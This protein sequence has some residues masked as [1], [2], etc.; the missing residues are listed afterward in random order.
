VP[1]DPGYPRE[2]LAFMVADAG[3]RVLLTQRHLVDLL[4]A[5]DAQVVCLDSDREL[6]LQE[7]R[8]NL[9]SEVQPENLF[10]VIYTSGS[11]GR[12]KGI[13]CLHGGALN[14]CKWMWETYPFDSH[15]RCGQK[16]S[17]SFADSVWEI[18]GP[19]LQGVPLVVFSEEATKDHTQFLA[20]LAVNDITRLVLVPS[21]LRSLLESGENL[22]Q[23]LPK[24]KLW[25]T[26]GEV[27]PF[28][29]AEK[30]KAVMPDCTL[31]NIY[32]SSEVSAD[33]TCH[34]LALGVESSTIP[35]G[36]PIANTRVYI[37]DRQ[38]Q[39]APVG[40]P[41]ELYIGGVVLARGYLYQPELTAERFIPDPYSSAAGA[42]LFKTGDLARYL[43]G[44]E[45]EY[46]GRIDYQVK[47]RGFRVELGEIET[48][49]KR[50][51][52]VNQSVVVEREVVPGDK[53][54][55]AYFTG[56]AEPAELRRYLKEQLPD[57]ML[58]ASFVRLESLPL[59]PNGK[60]DRRA[61]P[62]P[63]LTPVTDAEYVPPR[64]E[65]E[66][67]L[68]SIWSEV[69]RVSRVGVG[70]N[71]FELGGHSLLA[72]Q[73][74]AQINSTLQLQLPLRALFEHP[75][76]SSLAEQVEA[77]SRKGG[78][79]E[80]APIRR[81]EN[82]AKVA[83]SFAQQRLWFLDQ[84]EPDSAAYNIP[85]AVR[86]SGELNVAALERAFNEVV[87]RHESLRTAFVVEAGEPVQF[88]A[89]EVR[90]T[91]DVISLEEFEEQQREAEVARLAALEASVA[92]DLRRWPLLRIKLLRVS[93]AEHVLILV[94]HHIISDGWSM[95]VL[96]RDLCTFYNGFVS[97]QPIELK[98]LEVQYADYAVWQRGW[99]R[100]EVLEEQLRYWREQLQGATNSLELSTSHQHGDVNDIQGASLQV[101][102]DADLTAEL[103]EMSQH[104]GVTLFMLLLA[105]LGTLLYRYSGQSDIVIGTGV[106]NR[107]HREI[108][109]LIG[110]FVNVLPLRMDLTGNP[111]FRE[112]LRQVSKTALEAYA[113]QEVPFDKVVEELQP[114]RTHSHSPLFRV[115]LVLNNMV[116][117]AVELPGLSLSG[118][119]VH[120]GTSHFDL[121]VT[122]VETER[123]LRGTVEYKSALFSTEMIE[124]LLAHYEQVLRAVIKDPEQRLLEIVL[125]G[126]PT[127]LAAGDMSEFPEVFA[128]D[129]FSFDVS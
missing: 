73:V 14:R 61:L 36:C 88:I 100:G 90:L 58:P 48:V 69:L 125:T 114:E 51:A 94:M 65:T 11:T 118:M 21:L 30:F 8:T 15:E 43:P 63:D 76:I 98:D 26:S 6:I 123:G 128:N 5:H 87:R 79:R 117:P 24:L 111:T 55:V 59:T 20:T 106:A 23:R 81:A 89:D 2:R 93:A 78:G 83:L 46:L 84:L 54:L 80:S 68:T 13:S 67:L 91:L 19:L 57:Y 35:I 29:V 97:S 96:M 64:T 124:Q 22:A 56:T 32:G 45:I 110:F 62:A 7:S 12:P 49:L 122:L 42:R 108:K 75:Q 120:T 105:T 72:T 50:N 107:S 113:H 39:P 47:V 116:L 3:V 31:L 104:E 86:L 18:L 112:L 126:A 9:A 101:A 33:A 10:Y 37:L 129:Q 85:V 28:D 70:A 4:P 17:L 119:D 92:F 74:I 1:L 66:A 95:G 99:L 82:R 115:V 41:G 52:K 16:T 60:L 27:L 38:L 25:T 71:F 77:W 127:A 34:D 109:D 121:T 44:G 40:V 102:Y 103:K 53:R